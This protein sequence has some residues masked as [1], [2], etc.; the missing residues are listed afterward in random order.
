[1]HDA[2]VVMSANVVK[3]VAD[4]HGALWAVPDR[5]GLTR[6][7]P[8]TGRTRHFTKRDGLPARSIRSAAA[9]PDGDVWF[10]TMAGPVRYRHD[11]DRLDLPLGPPRS[12]TVMTVVGHD[13]SGRVAVAASQRGVGRVTEA[14]V[15]W[16]APAAS[17]P[18]ALQWRALVLDDDGSFWLATQSGGLWRYDSES[19]TG[20]WSSALPDVPVL[21]LTRGPDG[22][23]WIP[24]QGHGLW[25]VP[26]D[27]GTPRQAPFSDE[28]PRALWDVQAHRDGS[29]HVA[30]EWDGVFRVDRD[31]RVVDRITVPRLPVVDAL[32]LARTPAGLWVGH[33]GGVS[34]VSPTDGTAR[35]VLRQAQGIGGAVHDL[36][37]TQGGVVAAVGGSGV[38]NLT[39]KGFTTLGR[40][41]GVSSNEVWDVD[42]APTEH[43]H[44]V[45]WAATLYGLSR[46]VGRRDRHER[47]EMPTAEAPSLRLITVDEAQDEVWSASTEQLYVTDAATG[48]T[49]ALLRG[50]RLPATPTALVLDDTS[51]WLGT[52][53]PDLGL[54]ELPRQGRDPCRWRSYAETG[55]VEALATGGARGVLGIGPTGLWQLPG[56]G[57]K[58]QTV[59]R[60]RGSALGYDVARD[61]LWVG[62]ARGLS[63]LHD[64]DSVDIEL[65]AH[66]NALQTTHTG[67]FAAAGSQ[68]W[69]VR[70][71]PHSVSAIRNNARRL[72]H[73]TLVG[74]HLVRA[75][76][77]AMSV[78]DLTTSEGRSIPLRGQHVDAML[79][80]DD[81][82]VL[83]GL[84][85]GGLVSVDL[86]NGQVE[87]FPGLDPWNGIRALAQGPRGI[88]AATTSGL[89]H[90]DPGQLS[91]G[92]PLDGGIPLVADHVLASPTGVLAAT[93]ST[94]VHLDH[95]GNEL[96]RAAL[97]APVTALL[98]QRGRAWIG[99][100]EGLFTTRLDALDPQP[101][102]R[103]TP[104]HDADIAAL[105]WARGTV[106][107]L[108]RDSPTPLVALR[109]HPLDPTVGPHWSLPLGGC[110][111]APETLVVEAG[112]LW[113]PTPCGTASLPLRAPSWRPRD[114]APAT[115]FGGSVLLGMVLLLRWRRSTDP[116][117]LRSL[118][119]HQ[120]IAALRRLDRAGQLRATLRALRL[121]PDRALVVSQLLTPSADAASRLEALLQLLEAQVS[122]TSSD[123]RVA[124]VRAILSRP[125]GAALTLTV[126]CFD[127]AQLESRTARARTQEID[128]VAGRLDPQLATVRMV[129]VHRVGRAR[130]LL[131]DPEWWVLGDRQLATLLLSADPRATLA[132]MLFR[133]GIARELSP[134]G[135][136]GAVKRPDMFYG[137]ARVLRRI[138]S[139]QPPSALVVGPRR[140]GKS[141][142]LAQL[143]RILQAPDHRVIRLHLQGLSSPDDI[144]VLL[145]RAAELSPGEHP[146]L[147]QVLTAL[148][149][150][151]QVTLLLDEADTVAG[152]EDGAE[153]MGLLRRHASNGPLGV[154]M[155]GYQ[156][157]YLEALDRRSPAYNFLELVQLGPLDPT[158]AVNLAVEPMGR[159]GLSW[160][161]EALAS[162][163]V[164]AA[165]GYPH[166][167]QLLCDE[168]LQ[169]LP[170]TGA[171]E[172]T[173]T[174]WDAARTSVRVVEDLLLFV[175]RNTSPATRW[176]C[177]RFCEEEVLHTTEIARIMALELQ[178]PDAMQLLEEALRPLLLFGYVCRISPSAYRFGAPLFASLMATD[179]GR[180]R[181]L[182]QLVT[183][184]STP[185]RPSSD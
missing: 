110:L 14:R 134:Y 36:A 29:L 17:L 92:V 62:G 153:L 27:H 150:G 22:T 120:R 181:S 76:L 65:G 87:R 35:H 64:G 38:V 178:R 152:S 28:L 136:T 93:G 67:V 5:M 164:E 20:D 174:E 182:A 133:Q 130:T 77:D 78:E 148:L 3:L 171:S 2:P 128:D 109:P 84:A 50:C 75:R 162:E 43:G 108:V 31:G 25:Q 176:L 151:G 105:A 70:S 161:D 107:A 140:V 112:R 85:V 122:E 139:M 157:L 179:P 54:L 32:S 167:I 7:D 86:E 118:D 79:P 141:S 172:L 158:S 37:A 183:E 124:G 149:A 61:V 173:R 144:A 63:R 74:T 57:Q 13:A 34:V 45:S 82:S 19:S 115:A 60:A 4:A 185:T 83:L 9:A 184:L 125:G 180:Q 145:A 114:V 101:A 72:P 94:V 169:H 69:L 177:L 71:A 8:A 6:F 49:R 113:V 137:R 16:V 24:T 10:A 41:E 80:L 168:A 98:V 154:V 100:S 66:V 121:P 33:A 21:S 12:G 146:S 95:P 147:D 56:S 52:N 131:A 1:M 104:L 46:Q 135:T 102:E 166:L 165:G 97:P 59:R 155:T 73:T 163:L 127:E 119:G 39:S 15:D 103:V 126:L 48:Q 156:D 30:S 142:L 88:W 175:L 55:Q 91:E 81:R 170:P 89:F 106:W 138:T 160:S 90:L 53:A 42:V 117:D 44:Q 51:I 68:L 111:G 99:T 96:G 47:V 116:E 159:L 123:A 23:L 26:P 40:A 132:G 18:R 129:F 58:V 143:K 11:L